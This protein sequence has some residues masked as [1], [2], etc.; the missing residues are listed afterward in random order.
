MQLRF[1]SD[2]IGKDC[3]VVLNYYISPLKEHTDAGDS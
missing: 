3:V 2:E 1:D